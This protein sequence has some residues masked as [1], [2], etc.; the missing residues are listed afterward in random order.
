[1]ECKPAPESF[2]GH[3]W[4]CDSTVQGFDCGT[5]RDG[6]AMACFAAHQLGGQDFCAET[7]DGRAESSTDRSICFESRLKLERCDPS[8]LSTGP[9]RPCPAGLG[10]Y[11]TDLFQNE[12]ICTSAALCTFDNDCKSP[13]RNRCATT[14]LGLYF[15]SGDLAKDPSQRLTSTLKLDH[16]SCLQVGCNERHTSCLAGESC[17]PNVLPPSSTPP[18]VCAP[19]CDAF[20]RCPPNWL[21][22]RAVSG[23]AAPAVCVPGLIGFRCL[24]DNDCLMGSCVDTGQGF[25]NCAVPCE[26]EADCGRFDGE[27][28]Q[29]FCLAPT[30]G[31]R[32]HCFT[33][34][35]FGGSPCRNQ[36]DCSPG[37]VCTHYSPYSTD[38]EVGI[39]LVPCLPDKTCAPRA[40]LAHTCFD[41]LEPPV[42]YPGAIGISCHRDADCIGGLQCLPARTI[43]AKDREVPVSICSLPCQTSEDC[44]RDRQGR[45]ARVWC[46]QGA[47][48]MARAFDRLC[49]SNEQCAS[50]V[51]KPSERPEEG[52]TNVQR[53]TRPPGGVR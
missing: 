49:T 51:C 3:T 50:Q 48:V 19:D 7:C 40:G 25:R 24:S 37:T 35:S 15:L 47:C 33:P 30:P 26:S 27:R 22:Y 43:D 11:R 21:C 6:K 14:L 53:C 16:L 42:C 18:D 13:V 1:V 23:P 8:N 32:K 20:D 4:S 2:Y 12:G 5:T 17:L 38:V 52:G 10:C 9:D 39:C 28:G 46:D 34:S 41:Q 44:R 45:I 31:Q 36:G 29:F